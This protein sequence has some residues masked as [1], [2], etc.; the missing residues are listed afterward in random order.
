MKD[1]L[2]A[3]LGEFRNHFLRAYIVLKYRLACHNLCDHRTVQLV[4]SFVISQEVKGL[5]Q[6]YISF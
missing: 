1:N 2:A 6:L 3:I 4:D 5:D